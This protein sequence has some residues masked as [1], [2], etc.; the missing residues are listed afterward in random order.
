VERAAVG[1]CVAA[2]L[3]EYQYCTQRRERYSAFGALLLI[4]VHRSYATVQPSRVPIR[5]CPTETRLVPYTDHLNAEA[6]R[7]RRVCAPTAYPGV[8]GEE[9]DLR[10]HRQA[11]HGCETIAP[12]A[13]PRTR[14]AS[15]LSASLLAPSLTYVSYPESGEPASSALT[16]R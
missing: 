2:S 11:V 14:I 3:F 4:L 13:T 12:P 1:A 5:H 15:S 7:E 16:Q 6:P 9:Y 8:R 10:A